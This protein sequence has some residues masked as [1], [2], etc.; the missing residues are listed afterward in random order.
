MSQSQV[1]EMKKFVMREMTR[2]GGN[3]ER[4]Y[5]ICKEANKRKIRESKKESDKDSQ[6]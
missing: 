2:E 5:Q 4:A 6:K 3:L 1:A